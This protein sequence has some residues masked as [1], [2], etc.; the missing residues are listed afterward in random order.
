MCSFTAVMVLLLGETVGRLFGSVVQY[1]SLQQS[2]LLSTRLPVT[3]GAEQ[4][5]L[6]VAGRWWRDSSQIQDGC[7][8]W[9]VW[10]LAGAGVDGA[11]GLV[12][13]R[14]K[15]LQWVMTDNLPIFL[16]ASS[17]SVLRV[18]AHCH[19]MNPGFCSSSRTGGWSYFSLPVSG[20]GWPQQRCVGDGTMHL[21][22][23]LC[24]WK[25][26]TWFAKAQNSHLRSL[27]QRL[28]WSLRFW[29][30]PSPALCSNGMQEH[31][32]PVLSACHKIFV[33]AWA[34]CFVLM[35]SVLL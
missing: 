31:S 25:P 15:F 19:R 16:T 3:K 1:W 20:P 22:C 23:L 30:P 28:K 35:F 27:K 13:R 17:W 24:E 6:L 26:W 5:G 2:P 33:A 18:P 9:T 10:W 14:E 8:E 34:F 7:R 32:A 29:S 11:S 21:S 4:P 12:F